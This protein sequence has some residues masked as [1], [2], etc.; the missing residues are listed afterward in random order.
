MEDEFTWRLKLKSAEAGDSNTQFELATM[1]YSDIGVIQDR[2]KSIHWFTESAK[3]GH[4]DA[5]QFLGMT[6]AIGQDV[7]RDYEQSFYWL[8]KSA[9]QWN[10][11]AQNNLGLMYANGKGV[12]K[13][14]MQAYKWWSLAIATEQ[15]L[16]DR[17]EMIKN[18]SHVE[19]EMTNE[20]IAEAQR[21]VI[22]W[23]ET[24]QKNCKPS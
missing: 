13:D 21:L 6:Y 17:E 7:T 14:Y 9:E 4:V 16:L 24:Y 8:S 23:T 3:Q 20:E 22:E 11:K 10:G 1:Y 18:R 2:T 12:I 5:Q 19:G 15:P